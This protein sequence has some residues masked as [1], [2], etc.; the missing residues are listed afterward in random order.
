MA[1]ADKPI[2]HD[3]TW[4]FGQ[5]LA[6][7]TACLSGFLGGACLCLAVCYG[8]LYLYVSGLPRR[9]EVSDALAD[10]PAMIFGLGLSLLLSFIAGFASALWA[11]SQVGKLWIS[12]NSEQGGPPD[13][14]KNERPDPV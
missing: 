7:G 14:N 9:P 12:K 3:S 11:T 4:S 10:V 6:V 2:Q 13:P 5:W 1:T 8:F